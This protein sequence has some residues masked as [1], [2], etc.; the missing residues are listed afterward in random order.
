MLMREKAQTADLNPNAFMMHTADGNADCQSRGGL[1]HRL[2][3]HSGLF[4]FLSFPSFFF[5]SQKSLSAGE[6]VNKRHSSRGCGGE[7]FAGET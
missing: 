5:C 6:I 3:P 7:G 4:S 2:D 1:S